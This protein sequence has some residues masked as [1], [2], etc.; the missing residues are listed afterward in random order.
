LDT[1]F[2]R[3]AL[4]GLPEMGSPEFRE[5]VRQVGPRERIRKKLASTKGR[6]AN[7]PRNVYWPK[8]LDTN[9]VFDEVARFF[10]RECPK[11]H[12]R[13]AGEVLGLPSASESE[14]L[15]ETALGDLL[16]HTGVLTEMK[17]VHPSLPFV[18]IVDLIRS[19]PDGAIIGDFKTGSEQPYHSWQIKLYA[20]LWFRAAGQ[21]PIRAEVVYPA[22]TAE[23]ELS[24]PVL[25]NV[26]AKLEQQI[27]TLFDELANPPAPPNLGDHCSYCDVK[28]Y[29]DAY[30]SS[31]ARRKGNWADLELEVV[32]ATPATAIEGI[33]ID[34]EPVL[35]I[36][37]Q[38]IA[39]RWAPYR[40]GEKLRIRSAQSQEPEAD[41]AVFAV[42]SYSEVFRV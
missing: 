40:I 22:R 5:V 3:L 6:V 23:V 17:L 24:E 39:R 26:E 32:S 41:R 14:A 38:E 12:A 13:R 29:C 30:W 33:Q 35:V 28:Q 15:S 11:A 18:G 4:A 37:S 1:L 19:T 36:S 42:T 20:L 25:L 10:R 21:V 27:A 9:A 16:E 7:H 8:N 2:R 31:K 34:G